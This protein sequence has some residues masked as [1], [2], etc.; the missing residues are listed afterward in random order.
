MT[1]LS[2]DD[3]LI[4]SEG[5]KNRAQIVPVW[6]IRLQILNKRARTL[7]FYVK[8]GYWG[9]RD[10]LLRYLITGSDRANVRGRLWN[11]LGLR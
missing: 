5:L 2:I 6:L 8:D 1:G 10:G 3:S 9:N 11:V 7:K 4:G